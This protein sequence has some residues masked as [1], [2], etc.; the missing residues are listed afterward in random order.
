M[1]AQEAFL[2]AGQGTSGGLRAGAA[3]GTVVGRSVVARAHGELRAGGA[4][5]PYVGGGGVGV[6]L[7]FC[8]RATSPPRARARVGHGR[9]SL[10]NLSAAPRTVA[11]AA[12]DVPAALARGPLTELITGAAEP[13]SAGTLRVELPPLGVKL[14]AAGT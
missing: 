11:V 3:I 1:Q 2:K 4:L 8:G 6:E 9:G 14:L 5:A 12:G 7:R 13:A 10:I